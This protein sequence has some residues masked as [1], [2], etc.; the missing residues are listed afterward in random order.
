MGTAL[1]AVVQATTT[2]SADGDLD[3]TPQDYTIDLDTLG[4]PVELPDGRQ[5]YVPT[6]LGVP[7]DELIA[8]L[9][10]RQQPH[11]SKFSRLTGPPGTGKSMLARAVAWRLW[12]AQGRPVEQR[13]GRPFYGYVEMQP[14]PSSDEMFFR[15][16]FTPVDDGAG[17]VRLIDSA[18]VQ[19]MREGWTVVIDEA[20]TA[21]DVALLS[22]NG[23]LDGR[24]T[25]Y[26][27]ATGETVTAHPAFCP[28]LTYNPGLVGATDLPDAW[29]RRFSGAFEVASNW[30]A[31]IAL[32][33]PRPLVQ[34]FAALDR[35][36]FQRDSG[37]A[38][39]PQFGDVEALWTRIEAYGPGMER[40]AIA[41]WMS[42]LLEREHSGQ[43]T[44]AET[45]AVCRALDEAGYA[46]MK[47]SETGPIPTL[48]G[49]PRAVTL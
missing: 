38:W 3:A 16:E 19:A 14:G 6:V 35:R 4:A 13:H 2:V 11:R 10:D 42:D 44:A 28:I 27:P 25:L 20:N 17:G 1:T 23:T 22:I 32:G 37:L 7:L 26:L 12:Q 48:H 31:L 45:A 43:L 34:A 41:N 21:R 46:A 36:R 29:F 9:I 8:K 5:L 15:Y 40:L 33:A 47:V 49:Y 18:F 30:P 39:T 24:G